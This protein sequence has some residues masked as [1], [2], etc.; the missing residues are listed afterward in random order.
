MVMFFACFFGV[1]ISNILFL[2]FKDKYTR[3]KSMYDITKTIEKKW[4][5]N[6]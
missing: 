6:V 2:I 1:L 5:D 4:F 3:V